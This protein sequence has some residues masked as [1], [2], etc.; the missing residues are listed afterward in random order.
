MSVLSKVVKA[1]IILEVSKQYK[2]FGFSLKPTGKYELLM[3]VMT[4][5]GSQG[6]VISEYDSK[7]EAVRELKE[8]Y[9]WLLEDEP[10]IGEPYRPYG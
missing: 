10:E 8:R 5:G 7:R 6:A 1:E 4:S 2:G 9:G 3:H